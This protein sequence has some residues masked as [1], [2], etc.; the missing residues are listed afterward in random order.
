VLVAEIGLNG[1]FGSHSPEDWERFTTDPQRNFNSRDGG[2]FS[3]KFAFYYEA[4]GS[5]Y[6]FST[7]E[8]VFFLPFLYL[9]LLLL[10]SGSWERLVATVRRISHKLLP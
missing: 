4:T 8:F 1:L 7:I 10:S 6:I 2:G 3:S 5:F 9:L